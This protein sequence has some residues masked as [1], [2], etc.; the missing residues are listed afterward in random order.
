MVEFDKNFPNGK[1]IVF[2]T[3]IAGLLIPHF[4]FFLASFFWIILVKKITKDFVKFSFISFIPIFIFWTF[5]FIIYV[6][7]Y[8][9]PFF[10]FGQY[11]TLRSID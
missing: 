3:Q 11:Q 2:F 4:V 1:G 6:L 5:Y 8:S 7:D 9:V 10:Y